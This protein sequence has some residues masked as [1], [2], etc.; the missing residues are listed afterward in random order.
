MEIAD[1][2]AIYII[3]SVH[4]QLLIRMIIST[5]INML[6][7]LCKLCFPHLGKPHFTLVTWSSFSLQPTIWNYLEFNH[8]NSQKDCA[9]FTAPKPALL[10]R[11]IHKALTKGEM[12]PSLCHQENIISVLQCYSHVFKLG[13]VHTIGANGLLFYAKWASILKVQFTNTSTNSH[14]QSANY[15]IFRELMM[16]KRIIKWSGVTARLS[17]DH[18][19]RE[20]LLLYSV[21]NISHYSH[22]YY[23]CHG[24]QRF[25]CVEEVAVHGC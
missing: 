18:G 19:I 8:S 5:W 1:H 11:V 9:A 3:M 15:C 17:T 21:N 24:I 22:M 10:N 2:T 7:Q 25:Q 14:T 20:H 6:N 4:W 13:D 16:L 23:N 12:H